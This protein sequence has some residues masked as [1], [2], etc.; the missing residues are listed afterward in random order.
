METQK[1]PAT[2]LENIKGRDIPTG[3][4]KKLN[5]LPDELYIIKVQPQSE[6]KSLKEI[7]DEIGENAKARGMTPEILAG[8]LD[9]DISNIF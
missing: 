1:M 2:V 6:Y 7:M 9:E 8:I 3:L 5:I 4:R